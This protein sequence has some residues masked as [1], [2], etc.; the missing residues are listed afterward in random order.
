MALNCE[1]LGI[2]N[3]TY[4]YILHKA[5]TNATPEISL[6]L[7]GFVAYNFLHKYTIQKIQKQTHT[8]HFRDHR[9]HINFAI[10][11]VEDIA[12]FFNNNFR[13]LEEIAEVNS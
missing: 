4:G 6:Y 13:K 1:K 12:M 8:I 11:V 3:S 9:L 10:K 5:I 7:I 2:S